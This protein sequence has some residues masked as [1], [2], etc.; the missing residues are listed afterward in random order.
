MS[1]KAGLR[2]SR[3]LTRER[4][5]GYAMIVLLVEGV[6]LLILVAR[7]SDLFLPI[8]PPVSFD[9]VSFYA[10]G[11]LT[12]H[13]AAA[14]AYDE[15]I[16]GQTEKRIYGDS[17]IPY[18][19]F[20]YPPIYE[21]VCA[22]LASLPFTASF[23]IFM[24]GSGAA[25]FWVLRRTVKDPVLTAALAAFPAAFLTISL[26]QNSFLTTALMGGALLVL[27]RRP[28]LAGMLFGALSYKPHFLLLVPV[29]LIAGRHWLAFIATAATALALVSL[30]LV[31]LGSA[32]WHAWLITTPL[33]Q[34]VFVTG[35]VGFY[36]LVNLFGAVRLI[37]GSAGLA[38]GFQAVA[39][40]FAVAMVALV[41]R[42]SRNREIRGVT[43]VAA[44]LVALPVVLFYDLLPAAIAIA[45]L[46][47]DARRNGYVPWEKTIL[48]L[49]YPVA[50]LCRGVGEKTHVPIGWLV[51]LGLLGLAL[52]HVQ[53]EVSR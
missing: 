44:T 51:A 13:G 27:D 12:D 50:L 46:I 40:L 35:R 24:V 10:A 36:H 29:A 18:F 37:G 30:S 49:M 6:A 43:L 32:P 42:G 53:R 52:A 39:F 38:I 11:D 19:G 23:V 1:L 48:S 5:R 3:W 25:Y 33:A 47:G 22:G 16:Q 34:S 21:L 9:Y 45:W 2:W 7:T 20:Y 41:W 31:A 8:N 26:G 15:E 28:L 4:V 17:R 14:L